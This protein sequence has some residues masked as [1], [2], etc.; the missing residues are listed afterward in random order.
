MKTLVLE[1]TQAA[2]CRDVIEAGSLS[3]NFISACR[4]EAIFFPV[5]AASCR[6]VSEAGSHPSECRFFFCDK[7]VPDDKFRYPF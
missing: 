6:E 2:S 5:G 3:R 4:A 1:W 7:A